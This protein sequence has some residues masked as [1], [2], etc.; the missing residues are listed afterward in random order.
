MQ[1]KPCSE[2]WLL[3]GR[4]GTGYARKLEIARPDLWNSVINLFCC[5]ESSTGTLI[6]WCCSQHCFPSTFISTIIAVVYWDSINFQNQIHQVKYKLY[7]C[8]YRHNHKDMCCSD[9]VSMGSWWSN[10]LSQT[11]MSQQL[12]DGW[13]QMFI[14]DELLSLWP[15]FTFP[16]APPLDIPISL[17]LKSGLVRL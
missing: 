2:L 5:C 13:P 12:L 4:Q 16:L 8:Q 11:K 14:E 10:T 17:L 1:S 7:H 15:S 6:Y 9:G 3:P